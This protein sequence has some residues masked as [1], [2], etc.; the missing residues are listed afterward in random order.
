MRLIAMH[1]LVVFRWQAL[2]PA[3]ARLGDG[4]SDTDYYAYFMD[5]Q[6]EV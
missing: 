3:E 6:R 1:P 5:A 2:V 4:S